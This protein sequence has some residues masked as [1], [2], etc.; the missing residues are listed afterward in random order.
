MR[1]YKW[2]GREWTGG[3]P[4]V[5]PISNGDLIA[6]NQ[7]N[8]RFLLATE[9]QTGDGNVSWWNS[10]DGGESFVKS[11]ELLRRPDANFATSSFIRNA[12]PDARIIVAERRAGT[13]NRNMYLL[14]DN[15]PVRRK[16]AARR[17]Q[18]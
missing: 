16:V 3:K 12:H 14:G 4:D 2:N 13:N 5:L 15:G 11:Q 8:I 17:V 1:H 10:T 6:Q 9:N 18:P 7:D